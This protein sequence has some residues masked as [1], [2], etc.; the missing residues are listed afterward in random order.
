MRFFKRLFLSLA[1][2]SLVF[3][4]P[5]FSTAA[6]PPTIVSGAVEQPIVSSDGNDIQVARVV[7]EVP[8]K[9]SDVKSVTA[10]VT[11]PD[12]PGQGLGAFVWSP[13]N[14]FFE[15]VGPLTG[16]EYV[17]LLPTDPNNPDTT[18]QV[19]YNQA[20]HQVEI[21]YRWTLNDIYGSTFGNDLHVSLKT[22]TP[23]VAGLFLQPAFADAELDVDSDFSTNS[24]PD[25]VEVPDIE[26]IAGEGDV[27]VVVAATD[28]DSDP[29]TY[30]LISAPSDATFDIDTFEWVP[31]AEDI[32]VENVQI[33]ATDPYG[34]TTLDFDVVVEQPPLV[35]TGSWTGMSTVGAP[36]ARSGHS[37]VWTG[38]EAIVWG[39]A[40][41][42]DGTVGTGGIY[43]PAS[44]VWTS[45]APPLNG[46][47]AY[48]HS[49]VWTGDEM[50]AWGGLKP[51]STSTSEGQLYDPLSDSWRLISSL[52]APSPRYDA[53]A[54]W[55][56]SEFILWGGVDRNIDGIYTWLNDGGRYDPATDSWSSISASGLTERQG[57]EVVFIDGKMLVWGGSTWTS[58]SGSIYYNDGAIYDPDTDVW[59]L[60]TTAGAP[61]GRVHHAL[62]S[63]VDNTVTVWG[64]SGEEGYLNDGAVYDLVENIWTPISSVNAP[65]PR[66]FFAHAGGN[67]KLIIWG[68]AG[69]E[70]VVPS[71]SGG[72]YDQ[73]TDT[74][75]ATSTVSM[76]DTRL[77]SEAVWTGSGMLMWSGAALGGLHYDTGGIFTP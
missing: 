44:N 74:W 26:I 54:A 18:S 63:L 59:T 14:G 37:L 12:V 60:M 70:N 29:I 25:F 69:L 51:D 36:T 67:G 39:G 50:L 72:V 65:D 3:S 62:Y 33:V 24:P 1:V 58:E 66:T 9:L 32:G 46:Y 47:A 19:I 10:G 57:A 5:G 15:K 7:I 38:S 42:D 41:V 6:N 56:G 4:H 73:L 23:G 55:T 61:E 43:D 48:L 20:T 71:V 34:T 30:L 53:S 77:L 11:S 21:I 8:G 2:L 22:R 68:G 17:N 52:D 76:P 40:T 49:A 64:G 35:E 16:D 27:A 75:S 13:E 28:V 45:I 31:D